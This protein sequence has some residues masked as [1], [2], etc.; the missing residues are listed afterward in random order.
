MPSLFS[1]SFCAVVLGFVAY[2][3]TSYR[4]MDRAIRQLAL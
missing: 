2:A 3:Y 4:R 1:A